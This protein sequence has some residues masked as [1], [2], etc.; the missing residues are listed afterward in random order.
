MSVEWRIEEITNL[1]VVVVRQEGIP[2]QIQV[3][4]NAAFPSAVLQLRV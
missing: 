2:P 4:F 1:L 3:Q